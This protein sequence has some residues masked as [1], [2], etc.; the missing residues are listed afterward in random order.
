MASHTNDG[1]SVVAISNRVS[2]LET[3]VE[4]LGNRLS[5][6]A[7]DIINSDRKQD[8]FFN[9]WRQQKET[10]RREHDQAIRQRQ[11]TPRDLIMMLAACVTMCAALAGFG[12]YVMQTNIARATEPITS[13]INNIPAAISAAVT[14]LTERQNAS[15]QVSLQQRE[16]I[17]RIGGEVSTIKGTLSELQRIAF[18]NKDILKDLIK[19][20]VVNENAT[21][22][23]EE[24]SRAEEEIRKLAD[25]ALRD[26][27]RNFKARSRVSH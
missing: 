6:M 5:V 26:E 1:V 25:E 24:K 14:P 3:S 21:T 23:L 8:A 27:L 9:E 16:A 17:E 20:S 22:Q 11:T 12:N 13:T 4:V 2:K 10:E 19:K 18:D 15:S 7:E